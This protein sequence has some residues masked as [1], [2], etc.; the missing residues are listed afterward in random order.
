MSRAEWLRDYTED[1]L[2]DQLADLDKLLSAGET[3]SSIEIIPERS[4][5][6]L[7]KDFSLNTVEELRTALT[8]LAQ[9]SGESYTVTA[10]Q[11]QRYLNVQARRFY[12]DWD[13]IVDELFFNISVSRDE[14]I[15][16]HKT[17]ITE[18]GDPGSQTLQLMDN[19]RVCAYLDK[20]GES[21]FMRDAT[22]LFHDGWTCLYHVGT[23]ETIADLQ[24]LVARKNAISGWWT[25]RDLQ[26]FLYAE[27]KKLGKTTGPVTKQ[28][29][30]ADVR[31]AQKLRATYAVNQL[32]SDRSDNV[33][34]WRHLWLDTEA[35]G[36][37]DDE[38]K[39][40]LLE[41]RIK[42][43]DRIQT[44][45]ALV[46]RIKSG[47]FGDE[48]SKYLSN[49]KRLAN[50]VI[51]AWWLL[52]AAEKTGIGVKKA[53]ANYDSDK[54][55]FRDG[56]WNDPV[57]NDWLKGQYMTYCIRSMRE[58]FAQVGVDIG[59]DYPLC[60][61]GD[62]AFRRDIL[63]KIERGSASRQMLRQDAKA[64]LA[65]FQ[66][67]PEYF[68]GFPLRAIPADKID[69]YCF[70]LEEFLYNT[71]HD[72]MRDYDSHGVVCPLLHDR[73][74]LGHGSICYLDDDDR[75]MVAD[76]YY[77]SDGWSGPFREYVKVVWEKMQWWTATEGVILLPTF[78]YEAK[79]K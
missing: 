61:E 25:I 39:R 53:Q 75:I 77:M 27:A 10:Q 20:R 4:F 35:E 44:F 46:D 34:R 5:E 70:Y 49:V 52:Q 51:V 30:D 14:V 64:Q 41:K 12:K 40:D 32:D 11:F 29:T 62:P 17:L 16:W 18:D 57:L 43:I 68:R 66:D 33:W 42:D 31:L 9:A 78:A 79:Q 3:T 72:A 22:E 50:D 48:S 21:M 69:A 67:K 6:I 73:T 55:A 74:V 7:L 1:S 60:V 59:N 63:G 13:Q 24:A 8:T 58:N 65:Y 2:D 28:L 71:F 54:K 36:V 76:S 19:L 56:L 37:D 26:T 47:R 15:S 38:I 45:K 23:I